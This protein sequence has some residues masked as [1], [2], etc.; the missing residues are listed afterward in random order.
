MS[1]STL[2]GQKVKNVSQI[3][4]S[5]INNEHQIPWKFDNAEIFRYMVIT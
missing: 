2:N 1:S 5:Q 3:L 4:I